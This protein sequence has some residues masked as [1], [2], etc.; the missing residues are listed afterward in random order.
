MRKLAVL[1]IVT[2]LTTAYVGANAAERAHRR[3]SVSKPQ[4]PAATLPVENPV[5]RLPVPP[6]TFRA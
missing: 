2:L 1:V 3:H 4:K 5:T 6:D